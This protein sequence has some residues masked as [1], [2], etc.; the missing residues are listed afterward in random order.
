MESSGSVSRCY[1]TLAGAVEFLAK[2]D[3]CEAAARADL[4]AVGYPPTN[5]FLPDSSSALG[6]QTLECAHSKRRNLRAAFGSKD[7]AAK[8]GLHVL[9]GSS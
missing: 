6:I 3:R 1:R 7:Y 8:A 9:V 5:F 4:L 2:S